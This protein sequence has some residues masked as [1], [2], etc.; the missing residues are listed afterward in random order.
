MI[1]K[2]LFT[3]F[4]TIFLPLM[5]FPEDIIEEVH[6][7][8][9]RKGYQFTFTIYL[10]Y[11]DPSSVMIQ[12]PKFPREIRLIRG[13]S[14]RSYYLTS[15]SGITKKKT[16][17]RYTFIAQKTGRYI[18]KSFKIKTK[19]DS[20]TTKPHIIGIGFYKNKSI[21]IPYDISWEKEIGPVY[22]GQAVPLIVLISKLPR[23]IIFDTVKVSSPS[24]GLFTRIENPGP[25][26]ERNVGTQKLYNV[27]VAGYIYTASKS[28]TIRI[29]EVKVS[30]NGITSVSHSMNIKVYPIPPAIKETGAI[31]NFQR[32]YSI[33]SDILQHNE[34]TKVH[35]WIEGTGNLNYLEIPSPIAKGM[36]IINEESEQNYTGTFSGYKG[37][38]GKTFTLLAT[39]TGDKTI[40]IPSFPY[41][42][43]KT[44]AVSIIPPEHII[45]HIHKPVD[46]KIT[47]VDP[48]SG[49]EPEPFPNTHLVLQ[50]GRY[51]IAGSYLWLLPGP[52]V[53]LVFLL[54]GKKKVLIVS[55]VFLILPV[56]GAGA[57]RDSNGTSLY[58][59]GR[60]AESIN[61]YMDG[62]NSHTDNPAAYYDLALSYYKTGDIGKAVYAAQIALFY[63]PLN[64][65][66]VDLVNAIQSAAGIE[67]PVN[68]TRSIYPDIFL[69]ILTILVNG[70]GFL[71]V[72]YLIKKK[73]FYFIAAILFLGLSIV[74]AGALAHSAYQRQ[75]YYG[76]AY[77]DTTE[78]KRIPGNGSATDFTLKKGESVDVVNLSEE[79]VFIKNGIDMKGWVRR[80]KLLIFGGSI[81]PYKELKGTK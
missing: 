48:L 73:S 16:R 45:V 54:A 79:Y 1:G 76:I 41:F 5:V 43:S 71:G 10:N 20:Y 58:K 52:L 81:N 22:V 69:F 74:T 27:P 60:Y 57:A 3:C 61:A 47:P 63:N 28:G 68:I 37:R 34:S 59:N 42:N 77:S 78:V 2:V 49:F 39:Q 4:L 21:H 36:T 14:I 53:F 9:V 44:K 50:S 65:N 62:L 70:A 6:P 64:R 31:G 67:Y 24:S 35:V 15:E 66:Y 8:P 32:V 19:R 72:I 25:I 29:P 13:P 51:Q 40:T 18:L 80:K 7:N 11:D 26:T 33:E 46:K 56:F 30:G 23:I 75:H 12:A 55:L 38:R 17:I